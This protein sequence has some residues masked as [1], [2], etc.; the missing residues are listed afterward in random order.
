M[1]LIRRRKSPAKKVR[2]KTSTRKFEIDGKKY[3]S[4]ALVKYHQELQEYVGQGLIKSFELPQAGETKRSK[5]HAFKAR[6]NGI[7]FDSLNESRYY[8]HVLK[9]VKAGTVKSFE[10]QKP[11]E[12]VPPHVRSGRKVRKAEYISDFVLHMADGS[13]KVIDVKGIETD[14]FK[15]KKKLVEYLYPDVEIICMHYVAATKEWL[16]AKQYKERKKKKV[17]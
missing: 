4:G 7:E 15:L 13:T 3:S 10:L 9:A 17:A 1:A 14:V 12:I 8:I 5:F 6:I 2:A 11:F 16:T